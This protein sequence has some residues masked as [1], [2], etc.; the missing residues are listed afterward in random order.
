MVIEAT[1]LFCYI[2]YNI[3]SFKRIF[4]IFI[5][6]LVL[7]FLFIYQ[8]KAGEDKVILPGDKVPLVNQCPGDSCQITI[9]VL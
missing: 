4:L 1:W 3:F 8:D 9:T 5:D 2:F 6:L 7:T